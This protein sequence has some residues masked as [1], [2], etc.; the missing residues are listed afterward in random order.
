ML[1]RHWFQ[2]FS[3]QFQIV[4][5]TI[6]RQN[7]PFTILV[8][9]CSCSSKSFK[10]RNNACFRDIVFIFSLQFQYRKN[11]WLRDLVFKNVSEIKFGPWSAD[12][13]HPVKW[14]GFIDGCWNQNCLRLIHSDQEQTFLVFEQR[15][16]VVWNWET[17]GIQL[18]EKPFRTEHLLQFRP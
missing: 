10:Y 15:N 9:K 13:T 2:F 17:Q 5:T 7:A 4:S 3:L 8:F 12:D 16:L 18:I 1:Q 14:A 6:R 11:A